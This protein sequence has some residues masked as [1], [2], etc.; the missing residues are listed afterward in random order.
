[1]ISRKIKIDASLTANSKE[2]LLNYLK[3][4]NIALPPYKERTKQH[5]EKLGIHL[6][7]AALATADNLSY[8]LALNHRDKPDF[9][10]SQ[11]QKYIG[12]EC[13]AALD[14]NVEAIFALAEQEG[15]R[16][17]VA[18]DEFEPEA[19]PLTA[20]QK[21]QI[22]DRPQ[23]ITTPGFGDD[24]MEHK[25]SEW[26][27]KKIKDKTTDFQRTDF[28]KYNENWLLI[29][30]GSLVRLAETTT[31]VNYLKSDMYSY[32]LQDS[33]YDRIFVQTYGGLVDIRPNKWHV[34]PR[35]DL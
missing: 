26:M 12:I 24:G 25:W 15:K 23:R 6:F 1:M 33:C 8:P 9:Q 21:R 30:D 32:W 7:L 3:S 34:H 35:I 4:Q 28:K 18:S 27:F 19:P 11:G 2:E 10:L 17:M 22:I 29:F 16:V 14:Q 13:T 5:W 31:A 20:E